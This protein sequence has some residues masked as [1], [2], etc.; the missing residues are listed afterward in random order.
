MNSMVA[1]LL[2]SGIGVPPTNLTSGP[3]SP[4]TFLSHGAVPL[5]SNHPFCATKE[6]ALDKEHCLFKG[7]SVKDLKEKIEWFY[8]HPEERDRLRGLY[9][10]NAIAIQWQIPSMLSNKC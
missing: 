10:K 1:S 4:L 5:I 9:Q 7:G 6:F 3:L 8:E 2:F